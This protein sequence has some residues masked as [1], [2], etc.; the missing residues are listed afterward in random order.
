MTEFA[1]TARAASLRRMALFGAGAFIA[2]ALA[3]GVVLWAK[4]G[5]AVFFEMIAAGIAY[6]F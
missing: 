4:L 1:D 6:C 2:V 5:T 3:A